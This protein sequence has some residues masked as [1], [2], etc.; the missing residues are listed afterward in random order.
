MCKNLFTNE[1]LLTFLVVGNFVATESLYFP[2]YLQVYSYKHCI[3]YSNYTMETNLNITDPSLNFP[4]SFS[5]RG[6]WRI[7]SF[8]RLNAG[9]SPVLTITTTFDHNQPNCYFFDFENQILKSVENLVPSDLDDSTLV[10]YSS[11]GFDGQK[12]I[13]RSKTP[14]FT[15][16]LRVQAWAFTGS[17]R[18]TLYEEA[19]F[20]GASYC[21][22]LGQNIEDFGWGISSRRQIPEIKVESVEIG[23]DHD[24]AGT[25]PPYNKC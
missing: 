21:L 2:P 11:A 12:T 8:D 1:F 7:Q 13:V 16:P 20:A 17:H 6:L 15:S 14:N 23:C 19:N 25:N 18:F 24:V 4:I 5:T 10:L 22:E 9:G 3:G